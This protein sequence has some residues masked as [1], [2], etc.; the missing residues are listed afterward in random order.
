VYNDN[1]FTETLTPREQQIVELVAEGMSNAEIA[2]K[3]FVTVRTVKY[4][5]SNVLQKLGARDRAHAVALVWRMR[6]ALES[7]YRFDP[8]G[9]PTRAKACD[10][11]GQ[12]S[13]ATRP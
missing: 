2:G 9:S 13:A 3:L 11:P 4:H 8:D 12:D 7:G 10:E 5:V 1:R 6:S